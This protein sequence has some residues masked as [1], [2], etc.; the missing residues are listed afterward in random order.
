MW[1]KNEN[2]KQVVLASFDKTMINYSS[3]E[4]V[5]KLIKMVTKWRI[6]L[7]LSKDMS[8]EELKMNVQFIKSN[9]PKYTIKDI[10]I[11]INYS[12]QGRLNVNVEPYGTFSPLYISK[13]LNAYGA[14]AEE[15]INEALKEKKQAERRMES[16]K[17]VLPYEEQ[18]KNRKEYIKWFADKM[19]TTKT[20]I[21]DFDN[22]LWNL[23]HKNNLLQIN[24][25]WSA[26]A[27][28]YADGQIIMENES[29]WYRKFYNRLTLDEKKMDVKTRREIY[30]RFY[31]LQKFFLQITNIEEWLSQFTNEKLIAPRKTN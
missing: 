19:K 5:T 29:D 3:A 25:K 21:G 7:G 24:E 28:E 15:V 14:H 26:E 11:A 27:S 13:I 17:K 20:Y 30:G 2:E 10:D 23:L 31:I 9:Y 6:M 1:A 16:E 8:E 4:D 18:I 22:V 12:L